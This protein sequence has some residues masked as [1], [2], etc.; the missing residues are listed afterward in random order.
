MNVR[1]SR[2]RAVGAVHTACTKLNDQDHQALHWL[3]LERGV[4]DYEMTRQILTD[5]I[6]GRAPAR[7]TGSVRDPG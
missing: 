6:Y 7:H 4:S 1:Y 5:Y 3:A 2:T